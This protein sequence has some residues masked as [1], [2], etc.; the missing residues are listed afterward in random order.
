MFR[1]SVGGL[2]LFVF[3]FM[4]TLCP[5]IVVKTADAEHNVVYDRTH[6]VY[7]IC[8]GS[9]EVVAR[10]IYENEIEAYV[11]HPDDTPVIKWVIEPGTGFRYQV[12]EYVHTFH[13]LTRNNLTTSEYRIAWDHW[14]CR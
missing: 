3:V 2:V 10:T 13:N 4:F 8:T 14:R 11:G 7:H 9:G 12:I 1:K 5:F 6:T